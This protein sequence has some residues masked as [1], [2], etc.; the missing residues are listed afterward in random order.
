MN[1]SASDLTS[2]ITT[3]KQLVVYDQRWKGFMSQEQEECTEMRGS[4]R[5]GDC[6]GNK[7][8]YNK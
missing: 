7:E 8:I 4:A 1:R 2:V 6:K 3:G 5:K